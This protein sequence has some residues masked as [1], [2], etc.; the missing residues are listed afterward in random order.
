MNLVSLTT[1]YSKRL[2]KIFQRLSSAQWNC[3][4]QLC[5]W[6]PQHS[7]YI[8]PSQQL[9]YISLQ[10]Y[11][12]TY[13]ISYRTLLL[14]TGELHFLAWHCMKLMYQPDMSQELEVV[15]RHNSGL[16]SVCVASCLIY[17]SS[18]SHDLIQLVVIITEVP[19]MA[20]IP[21]C[22]HSY[23]LTNNSTMQLMEGF[24][25]VAT[26]HLLTRD[27]GAHTNATVRL[28]RRM[29]TVNL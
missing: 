3:G 2:S 28:V 15:L 5:Y 23:S 26:T 13:V 1:V 18:P 10:P 11:Y 12:A 22:I 14:G 17:P 29:S 24:G 6:W 27:R 20:S 4:C 7:V 21:A 19:C 25:S 9:I 8:P 16:S